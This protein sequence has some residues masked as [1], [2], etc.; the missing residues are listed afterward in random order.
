M[1]MAKH[2]LD[3]LH[4]S[5]TKSLVPQEKKILVRSEILSSSNRTDILTSVGEAEAVLL[6]ARAT[7]RY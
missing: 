3:G 7:L 6:W 1:N 4:V 2:M 5:V